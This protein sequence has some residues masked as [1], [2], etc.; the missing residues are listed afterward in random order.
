V[1]INRPGDLDLGLSV[2][3]LYRGTPQTDGQTDNRAQLFRMPP[4]LW[5][6]GIIY[7]C[8][9]Y[10]F[11]VFFYFNLNAFTF[12]IQGINLLKHDNKNF[13]RLK[14]AIKRSAS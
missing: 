4:P 13:K 9:F 10:I 14:A 3:Q 12:M 1:S 8:H 7:F 6:R 5:G 11:N 2:L